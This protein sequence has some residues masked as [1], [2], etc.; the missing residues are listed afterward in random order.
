MFALCI[1]LFTTEEQ[2][3]KWLP[4]QKNQT[5]VGCYAQ[6][7]IGHGSNVAGIETRATFDEAKD[8]FVLQT[9]SPS[10]TKFW[11]GDLGLNS[12]CGVVYA[13]LFSKGKDHGVHPFF[14]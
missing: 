11:P 2:K 3:Q 5:L 9:P 1:E 7:E 6:T 13:R 8:E 10:A 14:Y 12:N 4:L